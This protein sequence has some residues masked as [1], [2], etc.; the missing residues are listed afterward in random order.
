[1]LWMKYMMYSHK[2]VRCK[3]HIRFHSMLHYISTY[4][5]L[6]GVENLQNL[7]TNLWL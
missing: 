2:Y 3:Y 4:Q 7:R 6:F 5:I 1:M